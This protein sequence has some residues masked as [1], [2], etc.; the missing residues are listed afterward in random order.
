M[1]PGTIGGT[2]G[3]NPV[4]CAAALATLAVM[5]EKDL[6]ARAT[7]IGQVVRERFERLSQRG[8][9]AW[10]RATAQELPR[11]L[12]RV[13]GL[14]PEGRHWPY[15]RSLGPLVKPERGSLVGL[16]NPRDLTP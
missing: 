1:R 14:R 8:G 16:N 3:G 5:E 4:A 2:L 12:R 13:R 11:P 10:P 9:P 6:N 7:H 15:L